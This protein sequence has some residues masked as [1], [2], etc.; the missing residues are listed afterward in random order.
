MEELVQ[1]TFWLSRR[2]RQQLE[3]AAEVRGIDIHQ[4]LSLM[5]ELGFAHA[6]H[7]E[8]HLGRPLS[9]SGSQGT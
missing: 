9:P 2:L 1:E 5:L 7:P 4:A 8:D 6:A 3:V